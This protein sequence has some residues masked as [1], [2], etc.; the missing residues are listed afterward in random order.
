MLLQGRGAFKP[1][2]RHGKHVEVDISRQVMSLIKGDQAPPIPSTSPTGASSTPTDPR[3]SSASTSASPATTRT[4]MYYSIYFQ[5][6][7]ATH[8]YA[9]G[10]DLQRQPRLRPQPDRSDAVD[11]LRTLERGQLSG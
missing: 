9:P 6:G 5:G 11:L 7:Y 2:L 1:T 8:G 10:A 3:Q 4:R